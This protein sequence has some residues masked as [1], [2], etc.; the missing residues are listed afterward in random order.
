MR[1]PTIDDVAGLAGVSIKTVSRVFN[2]APNVRRET[3]EKV[4]AAAET[5]HYQPNLSAR[6][7]ASNRT[8]LVGLV[9]DDPD[10][11][12]TND[13][14]TAIQS[15]SLLACR[16]YGYHLLINPVSVS[17]PKLIDELTALNRQVD[18]LIVLQPLSDVRAVNQFITENDVAC[19]RL[20]Q[21]PLSGYA[22]ISVADVEAAD[23]MTEHL[24]SLG[25][26]RIGFIMGH[27]EHGQSHDRMAG[28]RRALE[29]N[30]VPFDPKLVAQGLFD[31]DSGYA[32]ARRLLSQGDLPT[33]IFAS[34]D[35]MAM[36]VLSA[37]REMEF[38]V[39]GKLSVAGFDD[40]P[41]ARHAYP[42]LTTVRQPIASIARLAT[43]E[44][45]QRLQ[46][47]G[48]GD[49]NHCLKAEVILRASTAAPS[50]QAGHA[51]S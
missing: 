19:V 50:P 12:T 7:L 31:Y 48:S 29:R 35:P 44:L 5:L 34:N 32:C 17:S 23:E 39:P 18:G 6:Q 27:P 26:R 38:D 45:M 3:R 20:S 10:P 9:Y 30:G 1:R 21:R 28:Y 42:S 13:Y 24:L 37:A 40:S 16:D 47:G 4:F 49:A 11:E 25:H 51:S 2:R 41:L 33:A 46:N 14:V 8:F 22:S 36:G 43:E 15:G